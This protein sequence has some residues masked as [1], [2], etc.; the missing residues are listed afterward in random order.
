MGILENSGREWVAIPVAS[1][2]RLVVPVLERQFGRTCPGGRPRVRRVRLAVLRVHRALPPRVA[3]VP[4][5]PGFRHV[6]PERELRRADAVGRAVAVL[7]R[8]L[9]PVG[10]VGGHGPR[11]VVPVSTRSSINSHP[12]PFISDAVFGVFKIFTLPRICSS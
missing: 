9:A 2:E 6:R 7:A 12:V 11:P 1:R 5:R 3:P 4:R 8:P 10:A